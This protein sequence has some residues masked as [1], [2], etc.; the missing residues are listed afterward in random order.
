MPMPE[1]VTENTPLPSSST[2]HARR[3]RA[4]GRRVADGVRHEVAE[5]ARELLAGAR[6]RRGGADV[7]R[8]LVLAAGQRLRVGRGLEQQR[9]DVEAVVGHRV[10]LALERGQREEVADEALHVARLV[11]HEAEVARAL[12]RVEVEVLHRLDEAGDDG[13]RRLELVRDVGDEVAAHPR[14]RLDLRDVAREQ[15]LLAHA[16]GNELQRQ[17]APRA[18]DRGDEDRSRVVAGIDVAP[19]TPAGGRGSRSPCRDPWRGRGRAARRRAGSPTRCRLA[20]SSTMTP[21]GIASAAWRKRSII[22]LRSRW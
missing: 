14:D 11:L 18:V 2:R 22:C 16:E 4:A 7:E 9:H 10:V 17:R 8:D 21:S 6:D 13:Q 20:S 5:R 1:S 19:G 12:A 3:M 15:H